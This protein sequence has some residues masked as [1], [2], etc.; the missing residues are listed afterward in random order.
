LC[1]TSPDT[2]LIGSAI[3]SMKKAMANQQFDYQESS[4]AFHALARLCAAITKSNSPRTRVSRFAI[5]QTQSAVR[6]A[7]TVSPFC[8]EHR[9][10]PPLC[11]RQLDRCHGTLAPCRRRNM[12]PLSD[13]WHRRQLR[14]LHDRQSG[15]DSVI[16]NLESA[17][18]LFFQIRCD[19]GELS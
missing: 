8:V 10:R 18:D 11:L 1:A 14:A 16:G 13:V 19:F 3:S 2:R 6:A 9:V 17:Y 15:W 5:P 4:S 12:D 7:A